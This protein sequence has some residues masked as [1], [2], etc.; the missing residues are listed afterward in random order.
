MLVNFLRILIRWFIISSILLMPQFIVDVIAVENDT[1][2]INSTLRPR[3]FDE[4]NRDNLYLLY[5]S[6]SG[7]RVY[8]SSDI[9]D[10]VGEKERNALNRLVEEIHSKYKKFLPRS[11]ASEPI[12]LVLSPSDQIIYDHMEVLPGSSAS[13]DD[14]ELVF[15]SS[16][17]NIFHLNV[18][19]WEA[20]SIV[21]RSTAYQGV[22]TGYRDVFET[23][24][25]KTVPQSWAQTDIPN[26]YF[27]YLFGCNQIRPAPDRSN[28]SVEIYRRIAEVFIRKDAI[29][30]LNTWKKND[31]LEDNKKLPGTNI[32]TQK[33][34]IAIALA[35]I[36]A[37]NEEYLTPWQ[38]LK[39]RQ[40]L[41][42][43]SDLFKDKDGEH[44]L[45]FPF[46]WFNWES[47]F[48]D[49][50]PQ[51]IISDRLKRPYAEILYRTVI[52]ILD[53]LANYYT[54]LT[55]YYSLLKRED[56]QID[57]LRFLSGIVVNFLP[58]RIKTLGSII[59]T[60]QLKDLSIQ[61]IANFQKKEKSRALPHYRPGLPI[62][63]AEE[64]AISDPGFFF[65]DAFF[66]LYKALVSQLGYAED[67]QINPIYYIE[68]LLMFR[69][70]LS[71]VFNFG[72]YHRD[73]NSFDGV[74]NA[75]KQYASSFLP[76]EPTPS[77][78]ELTSA[79]ISQSYI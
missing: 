37:Y 74:I 25:I 11:L 3:P 53:N 38:A 31:F 43:Y 58:S 4:R 15:S 79:N 55:N 78:E 65:Q 70:A 7:F 75:A 24:P 14:I 48:D 40:I 16:G 35:T 23:P 12:E 51:I 28:L 62:Q 47:L 29:G 34:H 9:W 60:G 44:Y 72:V 42:Y 5:D 18:Q 13:E 50:N 10:K 64:S 39:I 8:L 76:P 46:G 17:Q 30:E 33:L 69:F 1:I 77:R 66:E 73:E 68:S 67:D 59:Y 52:K 41:L 71:A 49:K 54:S 27:Y 57:G 21:F 32:T 26:G 22:S 63:T 56:Q 6:G 19:G 61:G 2:F 45:I 20:G 36:G